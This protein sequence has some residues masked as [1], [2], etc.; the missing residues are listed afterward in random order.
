MH[1]K[2]MLSYLLKGFLLGLI[3]TLCG[4]PTFKGAGDYRRQSGEYNKSGE[5]VPSGEYSNSGKYVPSGDLKNKNPENIK[6]HVPFRE[7]SLKWPTTR[8][9]VSQNYSPSHNPSHQ[10]VDFSGQWRAPI[11]AAHDAYVVYVGSGFRGYGHMILLEYNKSWA[12]LYAHL[13]K[14]LVNEGEVVRQ[15]QVIG[16][17]GRSGRATG[18]HLHFELLRSKQPIDP[19][20]LLR[21]HAHLAKQ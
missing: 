2:D 9:K 19:I 20:P 5:Y 15:G 12:T 6:P 4:C 3:F 11:K 7:F 1:N 21:A 14:V 8:I 13:N 18:V 10:G 16:L 17:M